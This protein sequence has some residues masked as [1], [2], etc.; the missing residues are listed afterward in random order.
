MSIR[1]QGVFRKGRE[2]GR[3]EGQKEKLRIV[4][5]FKNLGIPVEQ[6]AQA[7]GLSPEEIAV[8]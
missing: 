4:R 7:T 2:E 5:N 6:I 1:G 8:L 3:E